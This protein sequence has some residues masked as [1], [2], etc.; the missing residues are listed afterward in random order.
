MT[1]CFRRV[2]ERLEET[3]KAT[4]E[5]AQKFIRRAE[6]LAGL[7]LAAILGTGIFG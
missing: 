1:A 7:I 5:L 4:E 3:K 6:V 2:D